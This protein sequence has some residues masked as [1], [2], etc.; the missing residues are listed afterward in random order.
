MMNLED[1][2]LAELL[3]LQDLLDI[4]NEEELTKE[5][6]ARLQE[7][8]AKYAIARKYYLQTMFFFGQ[9]RW[10]AAH[11]EK[12]KKQPE[13]PV[14][15]SFLEF[16]GDSCRKGYDFFSYDTPFAL[17]LI[18]ILVGL[19]LFG[20]YLLVN[21]LDQRPGS[22]PAGPAFVA[23]IT[24]AKDCQWSTAITQPTD[25]MHL[26]VGQQLQLEKGIAQ[27]TYSN[28][29]VVLL[30]G[31]ISFT[32]GS[33]KS[34]FLSQ[35]KLTARAE[36]KESRQFTIVTPNS[37]FVD[38]GTE[39]GV[40][41]DDKG[42]TSVAVFAGK[43]NAEAKLADGR[44]T[45]PVSFSKGEAAVCEGAQF[46]PQVAQ[47]SD[48]PS[49]HPQTT[50]MPSIRQQTTP[51]PLPQ[52]QR[53][54]EANRDLPNR[55]D[56]LVYYD[57][58]PDPNNPNVLLN[59]APTGAALNGE[60]QNATWTQ[61]RFAEKSALEF[62]SADAGVR[63]NLPGEYRQLTVIVWVNSK[64]LSN[65]YNGILM[66][67]NWAQPKK[68]HF[69][70]Q[71]SGQIIMN[72]YGQLN[73]RENG[74]DDYCSTQAVPADCFD[75][76]CMIAGVIDTPD[77]TTVYLNGKFLETLKSAQIPAV[78]IGSAMIGNWNK[79]T[80]NDKDFIRNLSGR[81]DELM[82]FQKALTAEEIKQIYEAGK[83]ESG[84]GVSK[85]K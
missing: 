33:P 56:L 41:I 60:I 20:S 65:K 14:S 66:S 10:Q 15:K 39:F 27:I 84:E 44:W 51:T 22:S 31:P 4:L 35:G 1:M 73:K 79:E 9:L 16:L 28:G 59:R 34:G 3:E 74:Q 50:P 36:T 83:P 52:Y 8:V 71:G 46:T 64:K 18:F 68:L 12:N 47:R 81:I 29:A 53:W 69:Q 38:F 26:Q 77:L 49:L 55:S 17:L 5:Q 7:I 13:S 82:V 62:M 11:Q 78:Q 2:P 30:E 58:Q 76:W 48:F 24:S 63:V 80:S 54:L 75:N 72:V 19:S 67:D 42:R 57:F 21:T 61:G 23:R 32:V 6:D 45:A 37:R 85:N 70:L 43:V 40:M 25:M